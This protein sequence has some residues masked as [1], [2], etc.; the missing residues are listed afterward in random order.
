MHL[1]IPYR[2]M[3]FEEKRVNSCVQQLFAAAIWAPNF[4]E[5]H[6]EVLR[7]YIATSEMLDHHLSLVCLDIAQNW[8]LVFPYR[9]SHA[10]IHIEKQIF[11]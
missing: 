8:I 2:S 5:H 6:V 7:V 9:E 10:A 3:C 1:D 4:R 11:R